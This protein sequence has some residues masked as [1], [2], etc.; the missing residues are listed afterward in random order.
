MK[1]KKKSQR[2]NIKNASIKK[3]YNSKIRQE[4]LDADYLDKLD[5]KIKSCKLPDGTKVTELEYYALFMKEWNNAEVGKQSKAKKNKFHRTAK[6]VKSCTDRNNA[7]NR[8]QYGRAKA[9]NAMQP[10][11]HELLKNFMENKR[12]ANPESIEDALID[13]IDLSKERDDT[14]D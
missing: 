8:D 14:T 5:N 9:M 2:S 13:I 4:Y 11:E 7:R 6:D 10:L 12:Q 1:R 3:H